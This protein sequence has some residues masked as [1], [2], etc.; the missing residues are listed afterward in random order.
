M[1]RGCRSTG[2]SCPEM[3]AQDPGVWE[4]KGRAVRARDAGEAG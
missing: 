3:F 1:W 4:G 2:V